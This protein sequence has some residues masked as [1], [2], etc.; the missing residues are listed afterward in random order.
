MS[1]VYE[2]EVVAMTEPPDKSELALGPALDFLRRLWRL[3]HA[4]ERISL[5][6]EKTLGVT[7][8][9][10]LLLR[11]VAQYPGVT[12]GRLA[13]ALHVHPGTI[14]STVKRLEQKGLVVRTRDPTDSRR[15]G[16][17][18]TRRGRAFDV[19]KP[20]TVE[21]A[22]EELLGSRSERDLRASLNVLETLTRLL[23]G[24]A[25][26]PRDSSGAAR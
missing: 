3:N 20:G 6:M 17:G 2:D 4:L 5:Q 25:L 7:A 15:V 11:C 1:K 23:E 21:D 13:R 26:A 16:L 14:S 12:P 19:N 10:R 18:L 22:A 24:R 9:Q 8:Q